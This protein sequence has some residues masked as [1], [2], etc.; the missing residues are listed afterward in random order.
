MKRIVVDASATLK[1][2]FEDEEDANFALSLLNDA[3]TGNLELL[4]PS[5]WLYEMANGIRSA[6]I[7]KRIDETKGK[8]LLSIIL[9]FTPETFDFS[10]LVTKSLEIA[11]KFGTSVYDASYIAL[12]AAEEVEFYTGDKTLYRKTNQLKFVKTISQYLS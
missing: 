1:W 10:P 11:N 6:I 3:A 5:L 9:R 12:A 8:K 2:I 7:R 4:S